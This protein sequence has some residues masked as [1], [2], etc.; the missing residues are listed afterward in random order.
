MLKNVALIVISFKCNQKTCHQT[1]H[2]YRHRFCG[3]DP[4]TRGICVVRR[5]PFDV[6]I[7]CPLTGPDSWVFREIHT[8]STGVY[9]RLIKYVTVCDTHGER[10]TRHGLT[11]EE[12]VH[13]MH[14]LNGR[15]VVAHERTVGFLS[16]LSR[17]R[18][19]SASRVQNDHLRRSLSCVWKTTDTR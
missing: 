16:E 11:G 5:S 19:F 3:Y 14:S 6:D 7:P 2:P 15:R 1:E 4:E 8:I 12:N 9:S 13:G 17:H 10:A 18:V